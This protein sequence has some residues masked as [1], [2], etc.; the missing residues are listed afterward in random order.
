MLQKRNLE[1]CEYVFTQTT[2]IYE[3]LGF[4]QIQQ[5]LTESDMIANATMQPTHSPGAW[6]VSR[7]AKVRR[8][9]LVHHAAHVEHH[10][11]RFALLF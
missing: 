7:P 4:G 9:H 6:H 1:C 3:Y 10:V 8:L 2:T 11:A 5:N